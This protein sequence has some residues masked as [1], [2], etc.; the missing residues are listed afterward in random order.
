MA[1]TIINNESL[2]SGEITSSAVADVDDICVGVKVS[3]ATSE[4]MFCFVTFKRSTG[5]IND[6]VRDEN[7]KIISMKISGNGECNFN[8]IGVNTASLTVA[9]APHGTHDGIVLAEY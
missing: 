5:N 4:E 9:V 3:G 8:L 2:A 7:G 6:F 1:T